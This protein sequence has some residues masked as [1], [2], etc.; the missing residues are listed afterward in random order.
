[1]KIIVICENMPQF[2]NYVDAVL[3]DE[4]KLTKKRIVRK[5]GSSVIVHID[6]LEFIFCRNPD[7]LRGRSFDKDDHIVKVGSWYNIPVDTIDNIVAMFMMR[8]IP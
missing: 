3:H 7:T 8:I 4:S 2:D 1:M 6:D 5:N